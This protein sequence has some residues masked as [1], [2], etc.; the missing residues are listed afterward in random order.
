MCCTLYCYGNSCC[1]LCHVPHL[2]VTWKVDCNTQLHD[3]DATH[4]QVTEWLYFRP[5]TNCPG[6][7]HHCI[8]SMCSA[9][10]A[11]PLPLRQAPRC[12]T[13]VQYC[14]YSLL[15]PQPLALLLV[16]TAHLWWMRATALLWGSNRDIDAAAFSEC[17]PSNID[18]RRQVGG[19]LWAHQGTPHKE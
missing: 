11:H 17:V 3:S 18:D 14:T 6:R 2:A 8:P 1:F 10:A 13:F 4:T 9:E 16:C 15:P 7:V 12:C 19:R 5:S